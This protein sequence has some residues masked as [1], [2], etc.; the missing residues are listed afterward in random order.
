MVEKGITAISMLGIFLLTL[1]ACA[2]EKP[3]D[4]E[5]VMTKPKAFVGSDTCKMCHLEHYDSWKM[6]LHSRTL[7]NAQNN[8]DAIIVDFDKDKIRKSVA[9]LG[10]ELKLPVDQIFIPDVAEI[11]YT[12]GSQWRQTSLV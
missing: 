6:T 7:Q 2:D 3:V 8:L 12:M 9:E 1:V 4:V 11:Q 5:E 10:P